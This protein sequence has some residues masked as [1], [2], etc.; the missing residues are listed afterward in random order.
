MEQ[1]VTLVVV[2]FNL[3]VTVHCHL[4]VRREPP[5]IFP[6]L[7]LF[8]HCFCPFNLVAKM[9]ES[10]ARPSV[11]LPNGRTS[12]CPFRN[13]AIRGTIIGPLPIPARVVLEM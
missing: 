13:D 10:L 7:W 6:F 12:C 3:T 8:N 1:M 4:R 11:A 9:A 2:F 5:T